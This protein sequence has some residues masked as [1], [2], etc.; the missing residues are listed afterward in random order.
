MSTLAKP[1]DLPSKLCDFLQVPYDTKLSRIQIAKCM[2]RYIRD[3]NL[4][5]IFPCGTKVIYPDTKLQLLFN[6]DENY[7]LNRCTIQG[8]ITLLF[9]SAR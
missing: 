3:N 5:K 4:Q 1:L 6:I 9:K 2:Y 8:H 7:L